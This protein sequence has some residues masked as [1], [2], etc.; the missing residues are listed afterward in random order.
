MLQVDGLSAAKSIYHLRNT[1][2]FRRSKI[3][4]A[5]SGMEDAEDICECLKVLYSARAGEQGLDRDFGISLDAVDK[6]TSVAK[7]LLAAEIVRKTKKYEPRVEVVRIE[8]DTSKVG[9]G[10]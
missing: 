1:H 5:S 10:Y 8:W 6:P 3:Q 9:Q 7:A 4:L 2:D